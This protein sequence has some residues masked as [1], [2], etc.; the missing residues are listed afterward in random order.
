MRP[1]GILLLVACCLV[2]AAAAPQPA[3]RAAAAQGVTVVVRAADDLEQMW[4]LR[5]A[6]LRDAGE[7]GVRAS[8]WSVSDASAYQI[9]VEIVPAAQHEEDLF[10]FRVSVR[11]SRSPS[12]D[13]DAAAGVQT[14]PPPQVTA[15]RVIDVP[16]ADHARIL[17]TVKQMVGSV[18]RKM[19]ADI[20]RG[21]L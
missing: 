19:R 9:T 6:D 21:K 11:G 17:A 15:F 3:G 5:T 18:A 12:G 16:W 20:L 8:G 4:G 13:D 1:S 14:Q 2:T 10:P 7:Q